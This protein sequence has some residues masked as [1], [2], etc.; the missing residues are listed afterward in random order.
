MIEKLIMNENDKGCKDIYSHK[1]FL[2]NNCSQKE[3][4][5]QSKSTKN[6]NNVPQTVQATLRVL[7]WFGLYNLNHPRLC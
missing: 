5:T 7:G 4:F 3:I 2:D 6:T 1:T